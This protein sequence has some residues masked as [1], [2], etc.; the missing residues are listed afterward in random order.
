M[1]LIKAPLSGGKKENN[2]IKMLSRLKRIHQAKGSS[3]MSQCR[4]IFTTGSH[5][6][7][8]QKKKKTSV[9]TRGKDKKKVEQKLMRLIVANA[10]FFFL[11]E[12][13]E[14]R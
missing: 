3:V 5:T 4:L 1:I 10:T 11:P 12:K 7:T 14:C 6:K 13:E 2:P 9:A 8:K